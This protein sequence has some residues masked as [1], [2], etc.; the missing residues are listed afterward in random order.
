M[1]RRMTYAKP[2]DLP[3]DLQKLEDVD[4]RIAAASDIVSWLTRGAVYPVNEDGYPSDLGLLQLFTDA[5]VQQVIFADDKYG[6]VDVEEDSAPAQLGSLRF[7]K[8]EGSSG[9]NPNWGTGIRQNVSP[10]VW[11][12]LFNA[13]LIK[14]IV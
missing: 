10:A 12:M 6:G 4:R 9:R 5:T 2:D 3:T 7:G 13:G 1:Y 14:G 8:D 11:Y